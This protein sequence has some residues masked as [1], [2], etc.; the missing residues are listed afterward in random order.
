MQA[1]DIDK[2]CI[3]THAP[4]TG[5]DPTSPISSGKS[6]TYFN[7]RSP[8][9]ER[10]LL[11]QSNIKS[12]RFQPTLPARGATQTFYIKSADAADFNPRSPHG[13]RRRGSAFRQKQQPISTHAPRTG[14]DPDSFLPVQDEPIFQPTLPARGATVPAGC[15]TTISVKFQPTLPARGA[16]ATPEWVANC[17]ANFN[18]RSPHGERPAARRR[19][20][21]RAYFNP[22]SPHGERRSRRRSGCCFCR[23]QPTLPARGATGHPQHGHLRG[24]AF[25]PTLPARGATLITIAY[26][27]AEQIS[28]HAPRTGSDWGNYSLS[29]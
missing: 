27:M 9:G 11:L 3:S 4:R 14:S 23:F 12:I 19:R 18:P 10:R 29:A 8:H 16:T 2:A 6:T 5:S 7:P 13:E 20:Q 17:S 21:S 25:Q 15:C 1:S 26:K 24:F 28:T 22:R